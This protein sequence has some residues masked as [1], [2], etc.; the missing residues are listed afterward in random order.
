MVSK[1]FN[2]LI[3]GAGN[4]GAFFDRPTSQ[5]ILTHAH[6]FSSIEKFNLV[7]FVDSEIDKAFQASQIWGTKFFKSIEEAFSKFDIDVVCVASSTESHY[8][9]LRNLLNFPIKFVFSEKPL[10]SNLDQA[11]EILD[12]YE[13]KKIPL[14]VNYS[15]RFTPEFEKIKNKIDNGL[16]GNFLCGNGYYTKGILNNGSHLIDLL[17]FLIGEVKHFDVHSFEFDFFN[18]D[19]SI[20]VTLFIKNNPFY[21][22]HVNQKNYSIFELDL[23]FERGR[24]KILDSGLKI[25]EYLVQES[26]DFKG[27][28]YLFKNDDYLTSLH[29]ANYFAALNIY[30]NLTLGAELKCTAQDAFYALRICEKIKKRI[31][32]ESSQNIALF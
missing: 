28:K 3:I 31:V 4:I 11:L 15:R 30:Q 20:S 16:Y 26:N 27:Y 13:N 18:N 14:L 22:K 19:P 5:K 17:N 2:V 1:I 21:V 24:V 6:A 9:I 23:L 7:G 12:L 8:G 25:E 32:D 10:V 29:N